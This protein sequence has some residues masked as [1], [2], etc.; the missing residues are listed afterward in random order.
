VLPFAEPRLRRAS[1]LR[2]EPHGF[3]GC[4]ECRH[5]VEPATASLLDAEGGTSADPAEMARRFGPEIPVPAWRER[6]VCS[7][8]G[9]RD[10]D[11][12]VTGERRSGSSSAP[13]S[14]RPYSVGSFG[15][16]R[17]MAGA[18]LIIA[19]AVALACPVPL[20]AKEYRSRDVTREFQREHPCPSTG[21]TTG[22][23]PGYVR[24]HIWPLACADPI[25]W[26]TCNGRQSVTRGLRTGGSGRIA[27]AR[28]DPAAIESNLEFIMGQLAKVPTRNQLARYSLLVMLGTACLVQTLEFLFR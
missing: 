17:P 22:A 10:T 16:S 23:C 28:A 18:S 24:D 9:S 6:L 7:R 1:R 4:L 26:P 12:V 14:S 21:K 2:R 15:I 3:A 27:L 19:L 8:C 11:M 20:S 25:R 5:Q 13:R